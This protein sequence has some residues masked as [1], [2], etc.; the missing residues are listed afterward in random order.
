MPRRGSG[1]LAHWPDSWNRW[2]RVRAAGS[3]HCR[4]PGQTPDRLVVHEVDSVSDAT[5]QDADFVGSNQEM[6]H[7]CRDVKRA[8]LRHNEHVAV[9]TVEGRFLRHRLGGAVDIVAD[10]VLQ[11][12]IPR[13][14]DH[15]QA[16]DP[17]HIRVDIKRIPSELIRNI[18]EFGFQAVV[19]RHRLERGVR[20]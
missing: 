13:P 8:Q 7:F 18:I 17:I 16:A 1:N 14:G 12:G 5:R 4:A 2:V 6:A 19:T 11:S 9:G 20:C 3:A 15:I 10:A